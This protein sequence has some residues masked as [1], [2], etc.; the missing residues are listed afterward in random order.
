[1]SDDRAVKKVF[2]GK[3]D[4]RRK[5]A[6]PK[7]RWFDYIENDLKSTSVQS[8][9]NKAE[10]RSAWDVILKRLS[11]NYKEHIPMKKRSTFFPLLRI[12]CSYYY[13]SYNT[14]CNNMMSQKSNALVVYN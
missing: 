5:A 7:L 11:L 4:G 10:D 8:W 12:S 14:T 6:R 13:I 9:R 2:L 3:T 1:M